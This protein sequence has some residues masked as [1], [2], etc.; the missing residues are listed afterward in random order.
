MKEL[1][2]GITYG[3]GYGH[4]VFPTFLQDVSFDFYLLV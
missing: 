2:L 1:G 3:N 4:G